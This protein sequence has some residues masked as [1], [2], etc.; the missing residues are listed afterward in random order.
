MDKIRIGPVDYRVEYVDQLVADDGDICYGEID[1]D[2][3]VIRL[4]KNSPQVEWLTLLHEALHG[5][6]E[7][8][9]LKIKERTVTRMAAYLAMLIRDNPELFKSMANLRWV[10]QEPSGGT[11]W[12]GVDFGPDESYSLWLKPTPK[13]PLD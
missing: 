2:N 1:H 10:E 11:A 12:V 4:Q 7:V 6:S 9:G 13:S 5:V 8:Y 3:C